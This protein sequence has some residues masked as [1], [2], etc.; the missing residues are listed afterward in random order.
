MEDERTIVE[1]LRED[2]TS[3]AQIISS[4]ATDASTMVAPRKRY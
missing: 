2:D 3:I 4:G 1:A